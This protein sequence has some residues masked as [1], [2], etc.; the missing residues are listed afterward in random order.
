MV[1]F[2]KPDED[3]EC[4]KVDAGYSHE[5]LLPGLG[6]LAVADGTMSLRTLKMR[7]EFLLGMTWF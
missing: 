6:P 7:R 1:S 4:G 3:N 2:I 5:T